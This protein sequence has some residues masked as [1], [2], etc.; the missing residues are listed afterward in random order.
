MN[1]DLGDLNC[2]EFQNQ[3][4]ELI[5]AGVDVNQHPHVLTCE[6][7]SALIRDLDRIAGNARRGRFG[8]EEEQ[9]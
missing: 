9:P 4:G 8:T 2:T 7:C 3:L 6:L 1:K 5:A